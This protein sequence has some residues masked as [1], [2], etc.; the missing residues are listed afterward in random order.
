MA[1]SQEACDA[2]ME[3][4]KAGG[5]AVDAAIAAN[6]VNTVVEPMSCGI[7]GDLFAIVWN[8]KDSKLYGLNASG[9]SPKSL[10][11]D[12]MKQ[13]GLE[14]IPVRGSL[15]VSV[16]GCVDG[17]FELHERF[18]GLSMEKILAPA[19]NYAREGFPVSE[20]IAFSWQNSAGY[21]ADLPGF[22]EVFMPNGKAPQK[23]EV[24]RNEA[25]AETLQ[26][27]RSYLLSN[28]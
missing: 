10:T 15:P 20:T 4:L 7:G 3:I 25:L 27:P 22:A 26:K 28:W 8:A 1:Q 18:G 23:G 2:G 19:I 17:W 12:R 9:R 24:F 11:L 14:K 13:L 21:I 6:A 5:N 16:P